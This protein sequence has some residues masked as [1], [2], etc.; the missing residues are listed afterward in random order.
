MNQIVATTVV[1]K[2]GSTKPANVVSKGNTMTLKFHSDG[3]VS[4]KGFS[5]TWKKIA[6][7]ESGTIQSP[8]Y[9]KSYGENT[10]KTFDL[11]VADGSKIELTFT[12]FQV[13][14]EANCAYDYVQVFDTDGNSQKLCGSGKPSTIT[15][16]GKTMKV[17]FHSDFYVNMKGFSAT[18]KKV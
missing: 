15:S 11:A 14:T 3:S 2:C 8:N 17:K 9:P 10:D 7:T 4:A 12:D 13:E 16:S 5:A 18:W 6:A 1:K